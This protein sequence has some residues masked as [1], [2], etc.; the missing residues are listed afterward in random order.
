MK[1]VVDAWVRIGK[2][3]LRDSPLPGSLVTTN[4]FPLSP[5]DG[6]THPDDW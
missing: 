4:G 5:P 1:D 2:R 3:H 6:W